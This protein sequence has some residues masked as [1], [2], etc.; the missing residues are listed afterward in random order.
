[1]KAALNKDTYPSVHLTKIEGRLHLC[2]QSIVF[3][4][5]DVG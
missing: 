5:N 2:S 4:P 3:E 1:M